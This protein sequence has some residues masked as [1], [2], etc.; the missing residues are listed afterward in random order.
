MH[1]SRT[2]CGAHQFSVSERSAS[3]H[4]ASSAA[5]ARA[6]GSDRHVRLQGVQQLLV[7][8]FFARQRALL[9]AQGLVFKR[10]FSSGVMKRSAFFSVW[11]RR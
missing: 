2:N 10:F 11:R 8:P 1:G 6:S 5:M 7:Q 3:A 4:S 9:G